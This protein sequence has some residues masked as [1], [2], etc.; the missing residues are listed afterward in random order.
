MTHTTTDTRPTIT[1]Q[2]VILALGVGILLV[3]LVLGLVYLAGPDGRTD[4]LQWLSG[5]GVIITTALSGTAVA[6][7]RKVGQVAA[8]IDGQTNGV[9]DQ[10]IQAGV[11]AVLADHGF[12]P[13]QTGISGEAASTVPPGQIRGYVAE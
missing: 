10:R 13:V 8:K 12:Q 11:S 2:V 3:G 6:Q 9:L 5:I 7:V 1:T 4:V